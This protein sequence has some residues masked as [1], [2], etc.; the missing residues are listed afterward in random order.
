MVVV[1]FSYWI[2]CMWFVCHATWSCLSKLWARFVVITS[3]LGMAYLLS[4]IWVKMILYTYKE[5][6]GYS[7]RKLLL[8]LIIYC[9]VETTTGQCTLNT[10][11]FDEMKR[12]SCGKNCQSE[13]PCYT[14]TGGF[15][16]NV[17]KDA[18]TA[19][20]LYNGFWDYDKGTVSLQFI[21]S[22]NSTQSRH[23]KHWADLSHCVIFLIHTSINH[24]LL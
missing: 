19:M 20:S 12:C 24:Y 6:Y 9:I 2:N 13:Y 10:L 23:N 18:S 14:M 22:I 1:G 11:K 8:Q 21:C 15:V 16:S 5:N 4:C 3:E 17:T 7:W